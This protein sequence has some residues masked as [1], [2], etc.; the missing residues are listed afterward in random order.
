MLHINDRVEGGFS[1]ARPI[2]LDP[3]VTRIALS[4]PKASPPLKGLGN[5]KPSESY[6][7]TEAVFNAV[8]RVAASSSL[9]LSGILA[10]R[11]GA[12]PISANCCN[13]DSS[14]VV[15]VAHDSLL[16]SIM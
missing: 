16:V 6:K 13:P 9:M 8:G 15:R 1:P 5:P 12:V 7:A 2:T 10:V 4:F 14:S 11:Y 3:P